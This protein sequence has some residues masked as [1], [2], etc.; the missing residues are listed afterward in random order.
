MKRLKLLTLLAAPLIV[1][2]CSNGDQGS[3]AQ[4]ENQPETQTE[5]QDEAESTAEGM[6]TVTVG[7]VTDRAAEIWTD[8][9]SRLEEKEQIKVEPIVLTDFRQ[10]NEALANGEID[11]N[12]YQYIPFLYEFNEASQAGLVPLGYL[13]VEAMGIWAVDGIETVDDVPKGAQVSIYNDPTNLGNS[14][15]HLEKAGLIT[16]AEEAGPTPTVDDVTD[17]P[18]DLEFVELEAGQIPR[19][20][21]DSDLVVSGSTIA[22]ESGLDLEDNFYFED[23]TQT[24]RWFRLNFVVNEDRVDDEI[25]WKVLDEYQTQETV[26]F[27]NETGGEGTFFAGWEN[28]DD[29]QE[30][31]QEYVESQE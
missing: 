27:A 3:E 19:S 5:S 8:V 9:S 17:N 11:A 25:L 7:V 10:P 21:G 15:T 20:L 30:D 1:A 28:D 2:G 12:A 14:L 23:T 24:S 16:L 22:K 13:S 4:P 29:P 26:D 6:E 18:K 31:Y